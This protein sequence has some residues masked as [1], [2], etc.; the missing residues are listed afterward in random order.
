MPQPLHAWSPWRPEEVHQIPV[1]A[2]TDDRKPPS[3]GARNGTKVLW[4][5]QPAL[6]ASSLVSQNSVKII[7]ISVIK[8]P[9]ILFLSIYA[10]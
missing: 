7:N 10:R 3:T 9:A 4:E 1:I 2:A 8:D 6:S 5:K